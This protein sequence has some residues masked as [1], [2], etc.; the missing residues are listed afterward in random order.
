MP[1]CDAAPGVTVI[2]TPADEMPPAEAVMVAVP[3]SLPVTTPPETDATASFDDD[4]VTADDPSD[5][6]LFVNAVAVRVVVDPDV[7]VWDVI[8]EMSTRATELS[9]GLVV[10]PPSPPHA[11]RRTARH[12]TAG[13]TRLLAMLIRSF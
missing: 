9:G 12:R 4:H 7:N 6:L 13:R 8:G 2:A 3:A 5:L 11:D 1:S 10:P